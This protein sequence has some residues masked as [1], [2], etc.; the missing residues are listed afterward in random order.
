V[1][2]GRSRPPRAGR[3]PAGVTI[4]DQWVRHDDGGLSAI[5]VSGDLDIEALDTA[6]QSSVVAAFMRLCQGLETPLQIVVQVRRRRA[7]GQSWPASCGSLVTSRLRQSSDR[8]ERAFLADQSAFVRSVMFVPSVAR[9]R[10]SLDRA[11]MAVIEMLTSAGLSA[12]RL[13]G[14]ALAARVGEA[15]GAS[16]AV[17]GRL[18][19]PSWRQF[20]TH[21]TLGSILVRGFALRRLPGVAVSPGWLAP[22]LRI[23][24]ECDIALHVAPLGLADALNRLH[25]RLRDLRADQLVELDRDMFGDVGVEVGVDGALELRARLARNE[26]RPLTLSVTAIT[27]CAGEADL[28]DAGRRMRAAFAATMAECEAAHFRHLEAA[29][30]TW[31]LGR[32][33]LVSHK[34]V[35]T[36]AVSTLVPWVEAG[37]DDLGGYTLGWASR[38][39]APVRIAPFDTSHHINANIAVLAASGHGKTYAIGTLVLEAAA[40]EVASIIVDPEGEYERLVRALG[41]EY[42]A[43]APGRDVALNIFDVGRATDDGGGEVAGAVVDL[44]AILCDGHLDDVERALVDAATLTAL[45]SPAGPVTVLGDCLPSLAATS[46]RLG[47]VLQRFCTGP[48]GEL[49]NRP[50]SV[51][52]NAPLVG[53]GLR[54]LK[55]E[56]LPA[57]TLIVAEWLWALIR[58]ERR[59]RHVIFDEVGMLCAH[60][61][62]RT[63]L[64]QLARRCRKYKASLVVATQNASDLLSSEEGLVIATNPAVVLLGGHRAAETARMESAYGLVPAQRHFLELAGR[65]EFLLLAGNRR[66]TLR[67]ATPALQHALLTGGQ[68]P[69]AG[70]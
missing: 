4:E 12:E 47:V 1:L 7:L 65:G 11:V 54:D 32:D 69:M 29:M 22:L 40:R 53:I 31:P 20:A 68:L 41:G 17:P 44:V 64:V 59:E 16:V 49:F 56:L 55:P 52:L 42:V 67:I 39:R 10:A 57:A 35:D 14:A 15:W 36:A 58:R 33:P 26:G 6:R 62:L 24:A 66:L 38:N 5:I 61:P 2:R 34:L 19:V 60:A 25:R 45:R 63:L 37:C 50:T 48:L 46:E 28:D 18:P 51:D 30:T 27:R 70:C 21:A 9:E 8:H 13:S 23:D 43:L 3:L